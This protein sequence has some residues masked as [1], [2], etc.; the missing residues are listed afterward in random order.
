MLRQDWH[1]Y[2]SLQRDPLFCG[3]YFWWEI[4]MVACWQQLQLTDVRQASVL[5]EPNSHIST[6]CIYIYIYAGYQVP[7]HFISSLVR[8]PE[9]RRSREPSLVFCVPAPKHL[10]MPPKM[11]LGK[12]HF[13]LNSAVQKPLSEP[14]KKSEYDWICQAPGTCFGTRHLKVDRS[15]RIVSFPSAPS[16]KTTRSADMT[17]YRY[18]FKRLVLP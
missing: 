2:F 11:E 1:S 15:F 16:N 9:L 18:A 13:A 4:T 3:L 10:Q 6:L 14:I 8:I 17:P 5:T 7:V 12:D